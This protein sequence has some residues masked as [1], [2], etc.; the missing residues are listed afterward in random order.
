MSG[1]VMPWVPLGIL[2]GCPAYL[3]LMAAAL[4]ACGVPRAEIAKW[5]LRQADRQ[6]F[7]DLIR[8]ARGLPAAPAV[9]PDEKP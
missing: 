8:A 1:F 4:A 9:P 6:R 3:I 7:A 2:I 5:A